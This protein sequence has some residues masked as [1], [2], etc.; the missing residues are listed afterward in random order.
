MHLAVAP[1]CNIKCNYCDRKYDCVNESRPGIT[2]KVITPDEALEKVINQ[3]KVYNNINVIGIA[4]PGDPLANKET[5]QTFDLISDK[6]PDL[7]LCISTNGLLLK[8]NIKKL[9]KYNIKTVTVTVNSTN[10]DIQSKIVDHIY[11]NNKIYYGIGGASILIKNQI[12]GIKSAIKKGIFIK[13]NVVLIPT[14]ND[15]D[16]INLSKEMSNLGVYIMNIMP[17]IPQD[18][19]KELKRPSKLVIKKIQ[20]ECSLYIKQMTHC[21]QCRA[22]AVG[23]L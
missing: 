11:Y 4:G 23:L 16:I 5:I 7:N 17:L 12:E 19:F 10:P 22:D 2:S 3:L 14:I 1:N 18:K 21:K 15:N 20:E 9:S 13:V 6:F 8:D